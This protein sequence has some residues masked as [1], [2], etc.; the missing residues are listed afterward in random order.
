MPVAGHIVK[1]LKLRAAA[2]CNECLMV[3]ADQSFVVRL[4]WLWSS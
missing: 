3:F 2:G 1:K 4:C